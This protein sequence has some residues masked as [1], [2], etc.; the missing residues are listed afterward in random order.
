MEKPKPKEE[1][2]YEA[3]KI[4]KEE[5]A[6]KIANTFQL[7]GGGLLKTQQTQQSQQSQT[8]GIKKD[9]PKEIA[10]SLNKSGQVGPTKA[11]NT[12]L[13]SVGM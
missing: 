4:K 10:K 8:N 13:G 11:G 2:P 7:N 5:P 9:V 12:I 1:K 6:Y 3:V